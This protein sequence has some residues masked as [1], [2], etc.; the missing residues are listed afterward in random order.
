[1][2]LSVHCF[3]L[4][5]CNITVDLHETRLRPDYWLNELSPLYDTVVESLAILELLLKNK[6]KQK[7]L[8]MSQPTDIRLED[9]VLYDPL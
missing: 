3:Q 9:W 7:V 4:H 5:L 8:V 1:M 6:K 2:P